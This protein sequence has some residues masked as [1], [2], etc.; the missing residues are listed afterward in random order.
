MLW[1]EWGCFRARIAQSSRQ[2]GIGR[3]HNLQKNDTKEKDA[4]FDRH[5]RSKVGRSEAQGRLTQYFSI[6]E[7]RGCLVHLPR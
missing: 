2:I 4:N 5:D 7:R 1:L 6:R 3:V